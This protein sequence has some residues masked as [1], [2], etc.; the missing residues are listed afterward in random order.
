V[1]QSNGLRV[2]NESDRINEILQMTSGLTKSH[3]EEIEKLDRVSSD[4]TRTITD[5][6]N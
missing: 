2:K 6:S 3:G 4:S 5:H 1:T